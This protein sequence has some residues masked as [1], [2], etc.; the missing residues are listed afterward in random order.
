MRW[1]F[2]NRR[3]R[4][5][6]LEDEIAFDLAA[7]AA[8]NARAGMPPEDAARRSRREF[9]N[10]LLVEEATR[11]SWGWSF[12]DR[13]A[14]DVTYGFRLLARSPGFI[15]AAV[16]S[17]ALGIGAN[18]AIYSF[19]DAILLRALP[20]AD[21]ESLVSAEWHAK[22]QPKV[23]HSFFMG[24]HKDPATGFT[25]GSFPYPAYELFSAE[26]VFSSTFAFSPAGQRNLQV[27]GQADIARTEYVSGTYFSGL[28]LAPAIGRL[29]DPGDDRPGATPVA[30]MSFRYAQR[31]FGDIG[32][33]AGQKVLID[34]KLF[35]VA[36]VAPPEFFGADPSEIVDV[37]LP[38]HA[39]L[40]FDPIFG[41]DKLDEVYVDPHSYW[42]RV[43]ARIRPG[44]SRQQAEAV[45]ATVCHNFVEGSATTAGERADLPALLLTDGARGLDSLR[46]RYSQPLYVLMAMSGLILLLACANIANLLLARATA[47]RREMAVRLSM[48]ASRTRVVRQLLTESVLLSLAG[49]LAGVAIAQWGIR[50]LTLL[51]SDGAEDFTL[52]ADLNWH[53]LAVTAGLSIATGL[54]FGL[55]PAFEATRVDLASSLKQLSA[56]GGRLRRIN[57]RQALVVAQMAISLLLVVAGG[58]F[59]HTLANLHAVDLGFNQEH[60]LLFSVDAKQAGYSNDVAKRFYQ[61]LTSRLQA[62]PGVRAAS[63]SN[64]ALVSG[65][66]SGYGNVYAV[67]VGPG[68]F[69]NMQ[70][71][72][73]TGRAIDERD[74]TSSA[75][76]AVVNEVYVKRFL[77]GQN[78][79]GKR[80]NA[81]SLADVEIVGV[82]RN[83]RYSS[84]KRDLEPVAY[85]CYGQRKG[86]G[87]MTYELRAAGDPLA[88]AGAVRQ[89]VRD[90]DSRIPVRHLTT[91]QQLIDSGISQERTFATLCACFAVLAVL[92]ASVGIYGT[93]AYN[94]AQRGNEIGIRMALGAAR[95]TVLWMVLREALALCAAALAIGIPAAWVE[96]RLLE[97]FLFQ[98]KARDPLTLTVAPAVLLAAALAAG[99][100]PAWRAS[101]I[102]PWAALRDE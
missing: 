79:L 62:I 34:E 101:R 31:R 89:V 99:Y 38:L 23:I 74:M 53:A 26:S 14:Q 71:P 64:F 19:M 10:V 78:P 94:V 29:I 93:M 86:V 47:R 5:R 43:M 77:S 16:V 81:P 88:L 41:G 21:P 15:A 97:S 72:I 102:A 59:L 39:S 48:G 76:V 37:Y 73:L 90:A 28:G 61:D 70:I 13:L 4:H 1:N 27:R 84:L 49:G 24:G 100:G 25:S 85:L 6:E 55:A 44:V 22:D 52:H 57:S 95:A 42:L 91:Q 17:L 40:L 98:M 60:L 83:A 12:F 51:L 67:N 2:W 33:A 54:V 18:T 87:R 66:M 20:V 92:I 69:S 8:E 58:L 65:G 56:A 45:V 46:R 32:R 50:A 82:A 35:V 80:L 36:G 9:G 68:F 96:S 11:E 7:E 30:V 3:S 75:P 63:A